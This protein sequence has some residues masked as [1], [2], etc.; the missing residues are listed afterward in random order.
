MRKRFIMDMDLACKSIW[1]MVHVRYIPP[2]MHHDTI[3]INKYNKSSSFEFK[4]SLTRDLLDQGR[5]TYLL[6]FL[7][8]KG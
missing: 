1:L 5:V 7:E 8:M 3:K 6:H 4:Q 2:L